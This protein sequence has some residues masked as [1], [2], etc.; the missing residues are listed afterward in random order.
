MNVGSFLI[1][2]AQS[3][4]QGISTPKDEHDAPEAGSIGHTRPS[5]FQPGFR[6]RQKR[7]NQVPQAVRNQVGNH[8][9]P[10]QTG[11]LPIPAHAGC[12]TEP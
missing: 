5:A 8:D 4:P 11:R 6:W 10:P 9:A 2:D 7:L 12:V 3:A 1:T